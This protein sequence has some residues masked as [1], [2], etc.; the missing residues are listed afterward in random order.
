M[1][2]RFKWLCK[3]LI[4]FKFWYKA[5]LYNEGKILDISGNFKLGTRNI[6]TDGADQ[7]AESGAPDGLCGG[8]SP[9]RWFER[10]L[11]V[12]HNDPAAPQDHWEKGWTPALVCSKVG[13]FIFEI[14]SNGKSMGEN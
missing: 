1:N 5:S 6:F 13:W 11:T 2:N 14:G 7:P 8:Q 9:L 4:E 3:L 10:Y 12:S